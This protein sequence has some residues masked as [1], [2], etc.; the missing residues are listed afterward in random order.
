MILKEEETV[1]EPYCPLCCQPNPENEAGVCTCP[2]C[3]GVYK[4]ERN[5]TYFYTT[6][7]IV[8]K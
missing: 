1:G 4:L 6:T 3:D 5:P 7:E 2:Y 8:K